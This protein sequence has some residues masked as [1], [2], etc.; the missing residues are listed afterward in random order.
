MEEK[1]FVKQIKVG[2][3]LL[4]RAKCRLVNR[5]GEGRVKSVFKSA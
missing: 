2:E 1:A 3:Q 4:K 5:L